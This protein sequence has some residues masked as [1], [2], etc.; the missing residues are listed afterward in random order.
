MLSFLQDRSCLSS[1]TMFISPHPDDEVI[2]AGS[3][4]P[5]LSQ[6]L[7]VEVT[8]G[9]PPGLSDALAAGFQS[10]ETYAAARRAELKSAL[11]IAGISQLIELGLPDQRASFYLVSLTQKILALIEEHRPEV[12]ITVPYEGGH[13][14]HDAT[15]F[16]THTALDL[17]DEWRRPLLV[18]MLSYHSKNG[19]CDMF[20]FLGDDESNV[21]VIQ[22]GEESRSL[23]H[24]LFDCFPSQERVLRWFQTEVEKF[25]LAPQYDFTRPPHE[26]SLYYE[27]FPW[28]MKGN[29]WRELAASALQQLT[30]RLILA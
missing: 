12:L 14:D 3:R 30:L 16:A 8:D 1:K 11:S 18:E 9:S 27:L 5:L 4:L 22:L 15:A 25:R 10:R 2:G 28:G 6:A 23:K 20:D 24:R 13:P 26:G 29:L 19:A 21:L 17:I 7:V